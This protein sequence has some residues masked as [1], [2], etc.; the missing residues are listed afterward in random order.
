ME[1]QWNI[2]PP[3]VEEKLEEKVKENRLD[4][5]SSLLRDDG[6]DLSEGELEGGGQEVSVATGSL[7]H[8][9]LQNTEKPGQEY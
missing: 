3:V 5:R 9:Q 4:V 6:I 7:T 8:Q 2:S 1:D